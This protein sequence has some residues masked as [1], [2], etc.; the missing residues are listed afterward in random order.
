MIRICSE[1]F[2][3]RTRHR[4]VL[5]SPTPTEQHKPAAHVRDQ[6][7]AQQLGSVKNTSKY[8]EVTSAPGKHTSC[9]LRGFSRPK[10]DVFQKQQTGTVN[11]TLDGENST[12]AFK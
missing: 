9:C 2:P 3:D 5:G 11:V 10:E 6:V 1:S 8:H 4:T 7:V 12:N